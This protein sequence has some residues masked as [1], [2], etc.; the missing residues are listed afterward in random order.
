MISVFFGIKY[1]G[2]QMLMNALYHGQSR[3]SNAEMYEEHTHTH[4]HTH[5]A[6]YP[7]LSLSLSLSL[8]GSR[9]YNPLDLGRFFSFLVYTQSVGL[10][11]RGISP[12]QGR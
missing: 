10:L 11:G 8:K 4:T 6:L 3:C 9:L 7:R 12:L 1:L 5:V 2:F